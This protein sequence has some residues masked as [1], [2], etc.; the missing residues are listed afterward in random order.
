MAQAYALI[1]RGEL[2]PL[3]ISGRGQIRV[4]R[5]DLENYI[6]RAYRETAEWIEEHPF[7]EDEDEKRG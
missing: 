5:D 1:G 3:K 7:G 2:R 4:G 6:E